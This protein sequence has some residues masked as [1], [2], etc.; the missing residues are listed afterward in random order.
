MAEAPRF[1]F[2]FVIIGSGFGGS[3]AALRLVEKG[4]RVLVLEKGRQIADRD[5]AARNWDLKRWLWL[6]ALGCRGPYR[7]SPFQ[8]LVVL[9]GVGVGG[10]SLIYANTL[11]T[12][13]PAFFNAPSWAYLADWQA[14]LAP[15][16]AT[17]R[18]MLGAVANPRLEAGD[19]ALCRL[20]GELGRLP[21]FR[22]TEVAVYFGPPEV[23]VAD[24]YFGGQGPERAGCRFCGG[25][26]VGCRYNAKNTLVKNYLYLARRA[27]AQIWAETEARD[28]LPLGARDGSDGYIVEW[29]APGAKVS[30]GM[31]LA[32]G[33]IFA[34]GV[35]G[36]VPLLLKLKQTC[37]PEL[38]D[39]VGHDVRTNS[40]SFLGFTARNRHSVFSDGIAIGSILDLDDVTHVEPVRH[41]AGSGFFRLLAAPQVR[42]RNMLVR[43]ARM[44][45][46]T[47]RHPAKASK[48]I[49]V[50]DWAKRTQALMLMQSLD[51]RLRLRR[52][53]LGLRTQAEAGEPPT[54][55]LPQAV[56][57]ARR[58]APLV[59]GEPVV[60][61][62]EALLGIP[63]TA[64]ILGGAV[65]GRDAGEGVIDAQN[66]VFGYANLYVCDGS[67]ISANLGVNPALT[68][69][70]LA[71]R[72]MARVP[73]AG[74]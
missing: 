58:Y 21:D 19:L 64:H 52:G 48:V 32:S 1:D 43:L 53:R 60:F 15:H 26:M 67:M 54:S 22:P 49:F 47:L 41:S 23:T 25:C 2:D 13:G 44:V 51:S 29:R 71:E 28:V 9:S 3:A 69:L 65:M 14:E 36:T 42:G 50:D 24:P 18:Q 39:R 16:Y 68:I 72:T 61:L 55:F 73:P 74:K 31:V 5:F 7:I 62:Q 4:Y 40:E 57:L 10:G 46:Y 63:T 20:A 34:G 33:V 30:A 37:L 66:R 27:G 12:P 17:A 8:H 11:A 70:A 6:P 59:G 35:L 45:T 38:S 56:D